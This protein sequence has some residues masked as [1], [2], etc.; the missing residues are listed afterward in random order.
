MHTSARERPVAD[1]R[2]HLTPSRIHVRNEPLGRRAWLRWEGVA[3]P[4]GLLPGG[5]ARREPSTNT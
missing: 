5:C 3:G 2:D 4:A 1:L